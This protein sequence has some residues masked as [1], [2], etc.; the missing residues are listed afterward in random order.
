MDRLGAGD[1]IVN[2]MAAVGAAGRWRTEIS[3]LSFTITSPS[4]MALNGNLPLRAANN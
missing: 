2:G 1:R 3:A 4:Q